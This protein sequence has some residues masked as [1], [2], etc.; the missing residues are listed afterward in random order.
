M[1]LRVV[2]TLRWERDGWGLAHNETHLFT[3][4]G[5]ST[6]YVVDRDFQLLQKINVQENGQPVRNLNELEYYKGYLL[7]NIYFSTKIVVINIT[8]GEVVKKVEAEQLLQEESHSLTHHL[9]GGEVL[10]GIAFDSKTNRMLL[11]G[12]NWF[13]VYEIPA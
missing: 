1:D 12:K 11:T 4:D 6:I 2:R 9:Q 10:N 13:Q 7:A 5:S 8:T 3:S